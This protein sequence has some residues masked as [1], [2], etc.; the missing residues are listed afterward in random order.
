MNPPS[1]GDTQL[2][3]LTSDSDIHER[4]EQLVG[5][6]SAR[7]LWLMFLDDHAVQLPLLIPIDTLPGLPED[8]QLAEILDHVRDVV[9]EIGATSIIVVLER[10]AA[11]TLTMHDIAWA[12][13]VRTGCAAC[14]VTLRAQLLSHRGGVRWITVDDIGGGD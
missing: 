11:D 4:V 1:F 7:Q 13:S 10:Y 8:G 3:P 9:D 2:R 6:A 14:G 12:R 5:R